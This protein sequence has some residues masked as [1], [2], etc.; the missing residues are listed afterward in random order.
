MKPISEAI[1]ALQKRLEENP[2]SML[3]ARLAEYLLEVGRVEEAAALC[4]RGLEVHPSYANAHYVLGLCYYRQGDFDEAEGEF[5]R[6]ILYDPDHLNAR[7]LQAQIMKEKDWQNAY[8]L[9]LKQVLAIDPF[10]AEA[11]RQIREHEQRVAGEEEKEE[12]AVAA[13]PGE[14]QLP[15]IEE[16][17]EEFRKVERVFSEAEAETEVTEETLAGAPPE[18][19]EEVQEEFER[20]PEFAESSG[21]EEEAVPE[22][23][24][25]DYEYILDDIFKDEVAPEEEEFEEVQET[26]VEEEIVEEPPEET[27]ETV[28]PL[29]EETEAAAPEQPEAEKV[30]EATEE[31]PGAPPEAAEERQEKAA[32]AIFGDEEIVPE[33]E[34]AAPEAPVPERGEEPPQ[35]ER[36]PQEAEAEQK[37]ASPEPEVAGEEQPPEEEEKPR[38]K[39]PIV[40]S[41]LGEIYAAQG[42]F[43]KAISVYEILL[44][45][46]P[47]NEVYKLK[48]EQLKKKLEEQEK[49]EQE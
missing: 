5:N 44:R 18:E 48:I 38:R 16:D 32:R 19:R 9:R 2:R 30:E 46:D 14:E 6:A 31:V 13:Y 23:E 7:H 10:D 8:L 34:E 43:A 33:E 27:G 39:E 49:G 3:F 36:Q 21:L 24:G 45:K 15:D 12:A 11:L 35:F 28:P 47:D 22:E 37:S 4:K 25:K 29:Q 26:V 42:H 1:E 41:T 40:T 17:Q 20:E